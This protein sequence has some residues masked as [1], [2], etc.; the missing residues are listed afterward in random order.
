VDREARKI[1][2]ERLELLGYDEEARTGYLRVRCSKGTYIRTLVSD[3]G[4]LLGTGG[5]MSSLRRTRSGGYS[6]ENALTLDEIAKRSASGE[7]EGLIRPV[8]SVFAEHPALSVDTDRERKIKNGHDIAFAS[9]NGTYRIYSGSGEF[10]GISSVHG[11][12]LHIIKSFFE[13][14]ADE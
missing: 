12:Q 7:T 13:T 5:A 9:A 14:E 6:V 8:D 4:E 1:I 11:N 10:L 3:L 2:I